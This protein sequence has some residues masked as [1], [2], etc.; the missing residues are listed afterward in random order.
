MF[1]VLNTS[2]EL[3]D[4]DGAELGLDLEKGIFLR[5]SRADTDSGNNSLHS[6][7]TGTASS[8][9]SQPMESSFVEEDEEDYAENPKLSPEIRIKKPSLNTNII[10]VRYRGKPKH[11][12]HHD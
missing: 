3:G 9:L 12:N 4:P 11:Y 10:E 7:S 6:S 2:N 8:K 5:R 1:S